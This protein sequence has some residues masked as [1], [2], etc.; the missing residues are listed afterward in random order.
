MSNIVVLGSTRTGHGDKNGYAKLLGENFE[1]YMKNFAIVLGRN[2][3]KSRVDVDLSRLGDGKKISRHHASIFFDFTHHQFC[4]DVLGRSGCLVKGIR[5][6]PGNPPVKLDS[7]DLIQIGTIKFYIIFPV[8]TFSSNSVLPLYR[9]KHWVMQTPVPGAAFSLRYNYHLAA[10]S[11]AAFEANTIV[12]NRSKDDYDDDYDDEDDDNYDEDDDDA[13]GG[14]VGSGGS[15]RE[16]G[17]MDT[18]EC[19]RGKDLMVGACSRGKD[20]LVEALG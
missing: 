3:K 9:P 16:K 6:L 8:I 12:K 15:N 13:S 4:I 2:S 14:G 1:F 17:E 5:H 7:L 19:S 10:A 20:L 11:A 18:Y